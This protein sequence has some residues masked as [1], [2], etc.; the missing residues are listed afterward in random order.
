EIRWQ[1]TGGEVVVQWRDMER[2]LTGNDEV[3]SFQVRMN[4]SSGVVRMVYTSV[5]TVE[6]ST[7]AQP[8]VGLRGP[9]NTFATNVKNRLVNTGGGSNTWATSANGTSNTSNCRFTS[10]TTP[11]NGQTYTFTPPCT[12]PTLPSAGADQTICGTTGSATMAANTPSSGT[13]VWSHVSGPAATI[14]NTSSPTTSVTG[15]TTAGTHVFR[16]TITNGSCVASDD[17][18]ITVNATPST[19]NAGPDQTTCSSGSAT[20]AANNPANGTGAWTVVSG[21]STSISQFSNPASRTSA[22]SPNGG[23]GAYTLRWTISNAPCTSTQDDVVINV[24]STPTASNAGPDQTICTGSSA[25]LAANT[26]VNGT[27]VWSIVSGPSTSTAQF[28]ST[29]ATNAVFTPSGGNGGY[30]LRWTISNS[31]CT[32]STNNVV[33]TVTGNPSASNAGPDQSICSNSSATL[34]ANNPTT[35]V[36]AWSVVS[37]PSTAIAQFSNPA[38]RTSTFTPAGGGGTYT[39][40]WTISNNPCTPSQDEVLVVVDQVPSATASVVPDCQAGTYTINVNET[41][42][43]SASSV[44]IQSPTGTNLITNAVIGSYAISGIPIG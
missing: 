8:Q 23:S 2:A 15:M 13:G 35:G 32:S 3:F 6:N 17:V 30:T 1:N 14:A 16:W 24:V 22:F 37:G 11:N 42:L 43:G 40:R 36:G 44:N 7:S 18:T 27:G 21:P 26:P 39:L 4:T 29:A 5:S 38:S 28:S 41:G 12:P 25:T 31:P 33:I 19:S 9:N 10:G 20:L 34:A